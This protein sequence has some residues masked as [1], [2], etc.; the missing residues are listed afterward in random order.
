MDRINVPLVPLKVVALGKDLG[1]KPISVRHSKDLIGG[2]KR[3]LSWAEVGKDEPSLFQAGI[4]AKFDGILV[5]ASVWL[6]GHIEASS[7]DIKQP[8]VVDAPYPTIFQAAV[9]QVRP[10]VRTVN[11]Q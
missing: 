3:R 7:M 5:P 10:P 9:T 6:A 1:D 11:L 4:G 8:S 2:E